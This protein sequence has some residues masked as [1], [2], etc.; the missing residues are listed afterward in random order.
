M[1]DAHLSLTFCLP[2]TD[3]L[4]TLEAVLA[5]ARRGSVRLATMQVSPCDTRRQQVA[6]ALRAAEPDLLELFL[7]RLRNL[8]CIDD[9]TLDAQSAYQ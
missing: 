7:A 6:I 3:T 1:N 4:D 8:Y 2:D 9:I 5:I